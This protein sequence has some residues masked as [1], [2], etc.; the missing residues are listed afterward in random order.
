M[1]D[2]RGN[3]PIGDAV[4][5]DGSSCD[6]PSATVQGLLNLLSLRINPLGNS[7]SVFPF[8]SSDIGV[9]MDKELVMFIMDVFSILSGHETCNEEDGNNIVYRCPKMLCNF[10]VKFRLV[11]QNN[12]ARG[13]LEFVNVTGCK[14][15]GNCLQRGPVDTVHL[16][17]IPPTLMMAICLKVVCEQLDGKYGEC[18]DMKI[19][20]R[21]DKGGVIMTEK[22]GKA[23]RAMRHCFRYNKSY[24][25]EEGTGFCEAS[26]LSEKSSLFEFYCLVH[27][28][29]VTRKD[30]VMTHGNA[31]VIEGLKA[32]KYQPTTTTAIEEEIVVQQTCMYCLSV[33]EVQPLSIVLHCEGKCGCHHVHVECWKRQF[34]NEDMN[35]YSTY[36]WLYNSRENTIPEVGQ[37]MRCP[38]EASLVS[39]HVIDNEGVI[40][41]RF[42]PPCGRFEE[43]TWENIF[44]RLRER[45]R[46]VNAVIECA[47]KFAG[48]N[49]EAISEV[50]VKD[51]IPFAF[52]KDSV[53]TRF[54]TL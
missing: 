18:L 37:R 8:A 51:F 53:S 41:Q 35:M 1:D 43:R 46:L 4:H 7:G 45:I 28:V 52:P 23:K 5:F 10:S 3:L 34:C 44:E 25:N 30:V 14:E 17:D 20:E 26:M 6:Q 47:N 49:Q 38:L 24:F 11:R 9:A 22:Q 21:L 39:V 13:M 54:C 40:L 2:G 42:A 27:R 16:G 29:R 48:S 50:I 31:S 32:C 12:S 19:L 15:S 36:A 33:P